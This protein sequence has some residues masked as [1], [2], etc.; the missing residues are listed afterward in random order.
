MGLGKELFM[1]AHDELV[2]IYMEE[3]P[4]A[5]WQEAYD[6]TADLASQRSIDKYA[7]MIDWAHETA[8]YK[9]IK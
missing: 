1:Q 2:E 5:T 4:E 9:D 7:D 6:K 8:K 3:H